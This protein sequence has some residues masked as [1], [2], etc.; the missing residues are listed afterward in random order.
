MQE[1]FVGLVIVRIA[2]TDVVK[3]SVLLNVELLRGSSAI[4]RIEIPRKEPAL[5]LTLQ[6]TRRMKRVVHMQSD[7]AWSFVILWCPITVLGPFECHC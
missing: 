3:I 4:P 1:A 5:A 2:G 6:Y 7:G